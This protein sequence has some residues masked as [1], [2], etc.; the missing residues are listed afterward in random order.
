MWYAWSWLPFAF[1][2]YVCFHVHSDAG[3]DEGELDFSALLKATKKWDELQLFLQIK[4][5]T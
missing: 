4:K 3:E 2:T 1:I 5:T